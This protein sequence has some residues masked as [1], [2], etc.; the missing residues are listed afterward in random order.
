MPAAVH[1]TLKPY[2]QKSKHN[3]HK[4]RSYYTG[5]KITKKSRTKWP[6]GNDKNEINCLAKN[7]YFEA[8]GEPKKGQLAVGFVTLNRVKNS[9]FPN[10]ICKVVYQKGRNKKKRLVAQFSW[11]LDKY[12]NIPPKT[13]LWNVVYHRARTMVIHKSHDFTGGAT[14]FHATYI[15]P[16]WAKHLKYLMR[17]N[18]HKFYKA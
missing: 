12:S 9:R 3:K 11:T 10:T 16:Y 18:N 6:T 17:I 13:K 4:P 14:F 1:V 2:S 7:M 5:E 15:L 8:R